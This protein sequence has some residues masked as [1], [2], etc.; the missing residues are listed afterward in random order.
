MEEILEENERLKERIAFL[1][2]VINKK[3]DKTAYNQI[4]LMIVEKVA[5]ECPFDLVGGIEKRWTRQRAERK[6]MDDLKWDL[7]VRNINDFTD[8]HIEQAKNYIDK[9]VIDEKYKKATVMN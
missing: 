2:S 3:N 4:R 6:L 9:Y 7:R 1:E 8:E 5:N